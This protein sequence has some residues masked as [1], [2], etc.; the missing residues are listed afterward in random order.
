MGYKSKNEGEKILDEF[1]GLSAEDLA[2]VEWLYEPF[3]FY[4]KTSYGREVWTTCC[5]GHEHVHT[6][7]ELF[8][9]TDYEL[10]RMQHGEQV[11][12]PFCGRFVTV[13]N[14]KLLRSDWKHKQ[15]MPVLFLHTSE[16]GS[17]VYAQG[18]WS[19]RD[20]KNDPAGQILYMVT[21]VYRFRKGEVMVWGRSNDDCSVRPVRGR[22]NL[23]VPEP[24]ARGG[25][26]SYVEPY[27]VI[28][29]NRLKNS[30]L[31]YTGYEVPIT[32]WERQHWNCGYLRADLANYLAAAARWPENVEMLRKA[33]L[34]EPV[35]D[36][37]YA[38][39]KNA[40]IMKWGEVDPRKALGLTKPQLKEW[41]ASGGELQ[42]LRVWKGIRKT[43]GSVCFS[44]AKQ[45]A[46]KFTSKTFREI[47]SRCN[48]HRIHSGYLLKYLELNTGPRC[49]GGYFGMEQAAQMWRDYIDAAAKIG[50]DL[51]NPIHQMPKHLED[52][53]IEATRAAQM[54]EV[55]EKVKEFKSRTAALDKR[56][57]F[58]DKEFFI[59]APIDAAEI[60]AEGKALHHC[61]GGY[62][63]RH[64]KRTT[65]IL[66]LRSKAEP[67]KP[68]V[69]IEMN[70]NEIR[71]IHGYNNDLGKGQVS[72]MVTHEKLLHD[73]LAWLKAGSKRDKEGHP[74]MPNAKA[75]KQRGAV[76]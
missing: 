32:E 66:F 46:E 16:D 40:D 70:G 37:V 67:D 71:Q 18:Y 26:Y 13:K 25:I 11:R 22:K 19:M 29:M 42:T 47:M 1:P 59:R 34:N 44:D 9:A 10:L 58:E 23:R 36:L 3:L 61:V 45:I 38:G 74:V 4:E 39:K 28:G 27:D 75:Q 5:H 2:E 69:T 63:E 33:G 31:K 24:A 41:M 8:T 73:W 30:F 60:V 35:I 64:A 68:Y 62:A 72:P 76:A 6:M 50:Y 15:Y 65:T 49:Y 53:H 56:Y 7:T 12:C 21:Y 43:G 52:K 20:L 55:E 17:T 57:G 54:L 14:H 48:R 51:S